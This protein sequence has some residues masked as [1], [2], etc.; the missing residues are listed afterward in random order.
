VQVSELEL[1]GVLLIEPRVHGDPRGF[2]LETWNE[3]R[4]SRHGIEGPFVQDNLSLSGRGTLRGLHFQEP[5]P[6]GKLVWVLRGEVFDVLVDIRRRS[7]TFG[8]WLGMQLSADNKR[9]L[10]VPP[11][12][13]HG[14][15]V[16][17]DD[18]LFAY[19]CTDYWHPECERGVR[20]DDP[21]LAIPWPAENPVVSERDRHNPTLADSRDSLPAW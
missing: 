18:A 20:W 13:A 3:E 6:Q 12:Y 10:Y 17:G 14:F 5:H 1:P 19:K 8:R 21:D 7:E 4:Y 16:I 11:G 9:Q 15:Q 2:L